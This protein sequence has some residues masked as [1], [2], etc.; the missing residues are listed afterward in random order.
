MTYSCQRYFKV[1]FELLLLILTPSITSTSPVS[2]G[3][4]I[5]LGLRMALKTASAETVARLWQSP[6]AD[7]WSRRLRRRTPAYHAARINQALRRLIQRAGISPDQHLPLAVDI[8]H[9]SYYGRKRT[10]YIIGGRRKSGTNWYFKYIVVSVVLNH[11]RYPIYVRP[12]T[13][14]T[15]KYLNQTLKQVLETCRAIVG[16]ELLLLDR[17]FYRSRVVNELEAQGTQYAICAPKNQRFRRLAPLVNPHVWEPV[18][19]RRNDGQVDHRS[20]T[21]CLLQGFQFGKE[22]AISTLL[23][24]RVTPTYQQGR[25]R[26][27]Q[28]ERT[29]AF[30]MNFQGPPTLIP[31]LYRKRW[32]IET[33]FRETWRIIP[34][35][36]SSHPS[37]RCFNLGIALIIYSVWLLANAELTPELLSPEEA[38]VLL[39][40]DPERAAQEY[41]IPSFD[42][43]E[44]GLMWLNKRQ[45][46]RPRPK[47]PPRR[48]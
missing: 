17:G 39:L 26:G 2:E 23:L 37:I 47:P 11:Y 21:I 25:R 9:L 36:A 40:E 46:R 48:S 34:P 12:L 45:R 7:T 4:L 28:E 10:S 19:V 33:L 43:R 35:C 1:I 44:D 15:H 13:R 32:G 38:L 42:C 24:I 20:A 14:A 27:Q 22:R 41:I 16:I 6:S 8:T 3:D 31:A 30:L 18:V 29:L 5:Q